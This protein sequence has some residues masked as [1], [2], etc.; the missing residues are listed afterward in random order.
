MVI[1]LK[2]LVLEPE[3]PLLFEYE[4]DFSDYELYG[5]RPFPSGIRVRGRAEVG[6]GNIATLSIALEAEL[7]TLCATCGREIKLPF[8]AEG[9]FGLDTAAPPAA[10]WDGEDIVPAPGRELFV[11]P[12]VLD[13]IN[14]NMEMRPLCPEHAGE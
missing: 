9:E 3:K 13:L 12:L 14:L 2:G 5:V 11:D 1:D 6:A 8:F 10:E 7:S 4:A